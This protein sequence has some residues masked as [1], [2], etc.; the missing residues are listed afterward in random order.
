[1]Q[2]TTTLL[3]IGSLLAAGASATAIPAELQSRDTYDHKGSGLCKTMQV[4][5]CDEAVNNFLIRD[6]QYRYGPSPYQTCSGGCSGAGAEG[7]T[8]VG[9]HVSVEGDGDCR[10]SGNQ[11][12]QDYQD[13]RSNG[14]KKCGSK[15]WTQKAGDKT[16]QCR[17]TV[18]YISSCSKWKD[19]SCNRS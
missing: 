19:M 3:A 2:F 14:A 1:M 12:W 7:T 9:C 13:L 16:L 15:H 4:K 18:N 6:N 8:V 10:R 5:Y 17:T 11:I